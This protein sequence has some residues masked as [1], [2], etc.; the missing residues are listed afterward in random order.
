MMLILK[1]PKRTENFVKS[2]NRYV[3]NR[4]LYF[5]VTRK[6]AAMCWFVFQKL[7]V[8]SLAF[9]NCVMVLTNISNVHLY[10]SVKVL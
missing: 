8:S 10:H 1:P 4:A 6:E 3:S 9:S 2:K 7:Q 5:E